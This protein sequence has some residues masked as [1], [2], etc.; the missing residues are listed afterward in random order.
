MGARTSGT[1][2]K[3]LRA[4]DC[5]TW[6]E[7]HLVPADLVGAILSRSEK[8]LDNH[9]P[10]DRSKARRR[11]KL[12]PPSQGLV[13]SAR[14][15]RRIHADRHQRRCERYCRI[16]PS[17]ADLGSIRIPT[18]Y[19]CLRD[20]ATQSASI[21]VF[22]STTFKSRDFHQTTECS[23]LL[24]YSDDDFEGCGCRAKVT[25]TLLPPRVRTPDQALHA[26]KS[27]KLA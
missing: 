15:L 7:K 13:L 11:G 19:G 12:S 8:P 10:G 17:P 4:G 21:A 1:L 22:R 9:R 2:G 25:C 26:A 16:R 27:E 18:H 6:R 20:D 14:S 3:S 24:R 5:P 23:R